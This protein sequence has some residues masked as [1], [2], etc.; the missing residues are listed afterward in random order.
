MISIIIP[1][2]NL[3]MN[4]SRHRYTTTQLNLLKTL[5]DQ[6]TSLFITIIISEGGC[7]DSR[8]IIIC[9]KSFVPPRQRDDDLIMIA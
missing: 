5:F 8:M 1:Y 7:N 4:E 3:M 2:M 9:C 6:S